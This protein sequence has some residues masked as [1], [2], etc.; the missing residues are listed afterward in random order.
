M[1]VVWATGGDDRVR[2]GS[3][4]GVTWTD[5]GSILKAEPMEL[6]FKGKNGGKNGGK[7]KAV[8]IVSLSHPKDG[9]AVGR[10]GDADVGNAFRTRWV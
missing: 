7:E 6:G 1:A 3:G 8:C 5:L 9:V 4:D 2:A 10:D